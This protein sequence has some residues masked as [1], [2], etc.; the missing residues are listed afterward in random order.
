MKSFFSR[1]FGLELKK[2]T[3]IND[4]ELDER[5]RDITHNK[6]IGYRG[7]KSQ[8]EAVGIQLSYSRVRESMLRVDPG[9]IALRW[10]NTVQRRTYSVKS[11]NELWHID[12]NHKLIRLI[13]NNVIPLHKYKLHISD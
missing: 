13:I 2:L 9:G 10:G 5:I 3:D 6:N 8:L 12:G 7:A 1:T 4:Y 11:P